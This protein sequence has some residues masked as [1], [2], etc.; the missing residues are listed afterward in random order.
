MIICL[1]C[2]IREQ[3]VQQFLEELKFRAV[4]KLGEFFGAPLAVIKLR[5]EKNDENNGTC[6]TNEINRLRN[7]YQ[8][9]ASAAEIDVDFTSRNFAKTSDRMNYDIIYDVSFIPILK[10]D[11]S[12]SDCIEFM[13]EKG[14]L[15]FGAT[16][17]PFIRHRKD[18]PKEVWVTSLDVEEKLF[19]KDGFKRFVCMRIE[20]G[21]YFQIQ[22][23]IAALGLDPTNVLICAKVAEKK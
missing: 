9:K 2:L 19:T 16:I 20:D 10:K 12:Y 23:A 7:S 17:I 1:I 22:L 8:T 21:S 5:I 6:L 14:Y 11:V 4:E 3:L 18:V 13:R 15:F